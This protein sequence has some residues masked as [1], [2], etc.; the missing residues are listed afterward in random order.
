MKKKFRLSVIL[1]LAI[2]VFLCNSEIYALNLEEM[3]ILSSNEEI[4]IL[5]IYLE[6]GIDYPVITAEQL[7]GEE[8]I[9]LAVADNYII[10]EKDGEIYIIC[11]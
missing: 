9:I 7:I 10:I 1:L 3:K 11:L 8:Y 5:S 2:I 6:E 4:I